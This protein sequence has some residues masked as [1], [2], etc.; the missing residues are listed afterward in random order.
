MDELQEFRLILGRHGCFI[1]VKSDAEMTLVGDFS[2]VK[3]F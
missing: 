1:L 2:G 3:R